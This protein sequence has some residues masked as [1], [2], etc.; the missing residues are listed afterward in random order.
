MTTLTQKPIQA[1]IET[2]T[3]VES[4]NQTASPN[5]LGQIIVNRRINYLLCT[6]TEE[7]IYLTQLS[8]KSIPMFILVGPIFGILLAERNARRRFREVVAQP[9]G[10]PPV[11]EPGAEFIPRESIT[12]LTYKRNKG[13]DIRTADR[14]KVYLYHVVDKEMGYDKAYA[15]E[16]FDQFMGQSN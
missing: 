1:D 14:G 11:I 13:I 4:P 10:K 9:E 3:E 5:V 16:V 2:E 15:Q 7:G 6:V 12:Q 8:K